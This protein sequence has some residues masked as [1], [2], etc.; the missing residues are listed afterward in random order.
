VPDSF[1][2]PLVA[3][4]PPPPPQQRPPG[5][6]SAEPDLASLLNSSPTAFFLVVR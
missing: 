5:D 6:V 2:V 3:L 1:H 4:Q